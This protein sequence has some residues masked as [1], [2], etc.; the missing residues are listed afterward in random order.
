MNR[1]LIL[2]TLGLAT[3][4]GCYTEADVGYGYATPAPNMVAVTT[5][6]TVTLLA[7]WPTAVLLVMAGLPPLKVAVIGK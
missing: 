7:G 1:F 6:V 5:S 3:A 2:V 4:A